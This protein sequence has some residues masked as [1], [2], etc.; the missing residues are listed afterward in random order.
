MQYPVIDRLESTHPAQS[1]S[2]NAFICKLEMTGKNN[3]W[4]GE[5]LM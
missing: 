5:A 1:E 4:A 3:P 2:Q